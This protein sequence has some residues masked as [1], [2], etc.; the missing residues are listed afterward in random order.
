MEGGADMIL[1]STPKGRGRGPAG[2]RFP[3]L[4]SRGQALLGNDGNKGTRGDVPV[5]EGRG[6]LGNKRR[7]G[8]T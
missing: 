8:Q 2:P 7:D 3:P 6:R 4:R 1:E 5:R